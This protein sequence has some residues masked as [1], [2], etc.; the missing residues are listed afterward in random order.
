MGASVMGVSEQKRADDP[1]AYPPMQIVADLPGSDTLPASSID[2]Q[3]LLLPE[4]TQLPATISVQLIPVDAASF[5]SHAKDYQW[6]IDVVSPDEVTDPS[7]TFEG[8]SCDHSKRIAARQ[9]EV[10]R[11]SVRSLPVALV[12]GWAA[13]HEAVKLV[14]QLHITR[15]SGGGQT[16][17][18]EEEEDENPQEAALVAGTV[19]EQA[20][21]A[22]HDAPQEAWM[23]LLTEAEQACHYKLDDRSVDELLQE[24]DYSVETSSQELTILDVQGSGPIEVVLSLKSNSADSSTA[25]QQLLLETSQGASFAGGLCDTGRRALIRDPKDESW[26]KLTIARSSDS[27]TIVGLY[28]EAT[29]K[30]DNSQK[31]VI[32]RTKPFLIG[33]HDPQKL[34]DQQARVHQALHQ[35][36]TRHHGKTRGDEKEPRREETARHRQS[37]EYR[38]QAGS[39]SNRISIKDGGR[40]TFV[41]GR[42]WYIGMMILLAIPLVVVPLCLHL[43]K[44]SRRKGRLHKVS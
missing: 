7:A 18:T 44:V 31:A 3:Q 13:G 9:A 2:V 23:S 27:I 19:E 32:Y 15:R 22:L 11:L 40:F 10:V 36:I 5:P 25:V 38:Q 30:T 39:Y 26:P 43:S 4:D 21:A 12:A 41:G 17:K 14:P 20:R 29:S 33:S 1:N 16:D 28:S 6:V 24:H 42:D 37:P 35:Q 8:G 34:V